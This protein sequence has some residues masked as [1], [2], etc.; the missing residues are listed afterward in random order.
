MIGNIQKSGNHKVAALGPGSQVLPEMYMAQGILDPPQS[1]YGLGPS[2]IMM[3]PVEGQFAKYTYPIPEAEGGTDI[4][5]Y[6]TDC[7][8]PML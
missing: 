5:M 3:V 2:G 6:W 8:N 1:W 4:H 7:P